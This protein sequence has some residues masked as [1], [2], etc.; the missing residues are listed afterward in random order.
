MSKIIPREG[1]GVALGV[2]VR[3]LVTYRDAPEGTLIYTVFANKCQ[4][5]CKKGVPPVF[6]RF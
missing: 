1:V 4:K 3:H 6:D 5:R 2:Q